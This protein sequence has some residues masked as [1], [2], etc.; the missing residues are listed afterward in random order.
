MSIGQRTVPPAVSGNPGLGRKPVADGA[1]ADGVIAAVLVTSLSITLAVLVPGLRHWFLLPTTL[2]GILISVDTVSWFRRRT[3]VF[4][5]RAYLGLTGFHFFY[6]TPILHVGLNHWISPVYDPPDWP[7]A[8]G[9]LTVVNAIGLSIYRFV[10]AVP[11]R[12]GRRRR[13]VKRLDSVKFHQVGLFAVGVGV[14]AFCVELAIFG[15]LSGFLNVMTGSFERPQLV[16]M[17]WL[18]I[19]AE[20]FPTIAFAVLAVRH[21][22]TLAARPGLVALLLVGLAVTQ[23]FVGGLKGSRSSTLWPVLLCLIL[24]HLMIREISRKS[25]YVIGAVLVVFLYGYG[26]YK[27]AGTDLFDV[28]RG[29]RTLSEVQEETGRD[30][31]T[32]LT[33]DLGRADVQALLLDRQLQGD[34]LPT[35]G[36]TYVGDVANVVPRVLLP[37]RPPSKVEVGTDLLYGPTY[38]EVGARSS[39]VYGLTG[40]AII[41]FGPIGGVLSFLLLGLVVRWCRRYYLDAKRGTGLGPK[42]LAP[43]LWTLVGLP[44]ADLDN[45]LWFQLKYVAPLAI[46]VWLAGRGEP[47]ERLPQLHP[48]HRADRIRVG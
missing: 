39:R 32:M 30:L 22:A 19:V 10:L 12:T 7:E 1:I 38:L 3:D 16:G 42:L 33:G 2:S 29:T 34:A 23:F 21:R 43:L 40:E 37:E 14:A 31:P 11:G 47:G 20:S 9:A 26:L 24:V 13:A 46:V 17:G 28:A 36:M 45:I 48:R 18:I 8:L 4:D 5:P 44:S 27:S 25:L 35:G 15:G 41:N 6:L